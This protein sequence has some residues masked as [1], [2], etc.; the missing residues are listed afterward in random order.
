MRVY[1]NGAQTEW[2]FGQRAQNDHDFTV[3]SLISGNYF[4]KM[5]LNMAGQLKLGDG[6]FFGYKEGTWTPEMFRFFLTTGLPDTGSPVTNTLSEGFWTRIGRNVT[7]TFRINF[8]YPI[9]NAGGFCIPMTSLI[10]QG[11]APRDWAS[12][13]ANHYDFTGVSASP[14]TELAGY[15]KP[16]SFA[17]QVK[18]NTFNDKAIFVY[19]GPLRYEGVNNFF[20][21]NQTI[22]G[23]ITYPV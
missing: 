20:I 4:E 3:S 6:N 19:S 17:L 21:S 9:G 2:V 13:I 5:R 11:L 12:T 23:T 1:N 14:W 8:N 18:P 22:S 10:S 7:L 16:Y 15:S